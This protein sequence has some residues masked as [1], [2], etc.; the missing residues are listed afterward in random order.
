MNYINGRLKILISNI[1]KLITLQYTIIF[2][3]LFRHLM[4]KLVITLLLLS[5]VYATQY[6]TI[7]KR[8]VGILDGSSDA[9][10]KIEL[11]YDPVCGDTA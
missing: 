11:I 1:H 6:V 9:A 2:S 7:P 8:E 4:E 10:V 3:L 5:V